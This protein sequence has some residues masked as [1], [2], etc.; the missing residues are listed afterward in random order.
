MGLLLSR[1]DLHSL[2]RFGAFVNPLSLKN[3]CSPAEK[4]NPDPHVEHV[5]S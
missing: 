4:T 2:H 3:S 1:S 5:K